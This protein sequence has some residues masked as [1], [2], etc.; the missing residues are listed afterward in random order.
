VKKYKSDFT[1]YKTTEKGFTPIA[2][3]NKVEIA[4]KKWMKD[5]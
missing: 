4:G 2:G 5:R 3:K 1:T